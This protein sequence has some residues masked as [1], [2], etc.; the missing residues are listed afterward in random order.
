MKKPLDVVKKSISDLL[1]LVRVNE[2]EYTISIRQKRNHNDNLS[3]YFSEYENVVVVQSDGS[4]W[5]I[6]KN[7]IDRDYGH[8]YVLG[9]KTASLLREEFF[10]F[11]INNRMNNV[12]FSYQQRS[13]HKRFGLLNPDEKYIIYLLY[14]LKKKYKDI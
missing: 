9:G 10:N 13:L 12:S 7:D 1:G 3:E 8:P 6:D 2:I 11:I 14:H 5:L 4:A